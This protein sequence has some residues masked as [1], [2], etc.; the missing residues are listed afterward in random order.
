[1]FFHCSYIQCNIPPINTQLT[2]LYLCP[3]LLH[4]AITVYLARSKMQSNNVICS[5]ALIARI[6]LRISGG[7]IYKKCSHRLFV[8]RVFFSF[9]QI[10]FEILFFLITQNQNLMCSIPVFELCVIACDSFTKWSSTQSFL[11]IL[12]FAKIQAWHLAVWTYFKFWT[13]I[14]LPLSCPTISITYAPHHVC[15]ELIRADPF[16][17]RWW[18]DKCFMLHR[19]GGCAVPWV[20]ISFSSCLGSS[21]YVFVGGTLL[22][23]GLDRRYPPFTPFSGAAR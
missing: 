7:Y 13:P 12:I 23:Q 17:A 21:K 3:V 19:T 14:C 1:M 6:Y 9:L 5:L 20:D 18:V 11:S 22:N 4:T 2:A 15:D 16:G 10:I 8:H